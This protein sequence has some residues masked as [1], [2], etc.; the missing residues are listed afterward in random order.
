MRARP[1]RLIFTNAAPS[2]YTLSSGPMSALQHLRQ[3]PWL[4]R[5]ALLWFV[6]TLGSAAALPMPAAQAL[7]SI[8]SASGNDAG[9]D[10][11]SDATSAFCPLCMVAG[12]PPP[13]GAGVSQA[14][15]SAGALPISTDDAPRAQR[16]R[17][18]LPARG[19]PQISIAI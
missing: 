17:A 13:I 15:P 1:I 8:C 3:N 7:G 10:T 14:V 16:S 11:Q 12:L 5:V 2:G 4:A 19:P 18:A 9:A 6:L